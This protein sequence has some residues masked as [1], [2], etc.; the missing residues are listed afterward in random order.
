MLEKNQIIMFFQ[1]INKYSDSKEK[2]NIFKEIRLFLH[3]LSCNYPLFD[4]WLEKVFVE[5][6]CTKRTII[7]CESEDKKIVGIAILKNTIKEKKICTIRVAKEMQ[8]CGIG[9]KLM[10]MS[11]AI[12]GDKRPLITV[13]EEHIDDFKPFLK[14]YGFKIFQKVKSVYCENKYEYFFNSP[15]IHENVIMSIKPKYADKILN[16]EKKVEFRKKV[17]PNTVNKVYIY[18]S[19]PVMRIVGLFVVDYIEKGTPDEI[20]KNNKEHGGITERAFREYFDGNIAHAIHIREIKCFRK[21]I[22]LSDIFTLQYKAPQ[23][24]RYIDNVL[25]LEKLNNCE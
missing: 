11:L 16:G 7:Y 9:S 10:D 25:A 20:W 15:C 21:P 23:N 18:S 8:H 6:N 17:F 1:I 12:L 3:E 13:S 22:L 4:K 24:F 14:H 5:T 19:F 2:H